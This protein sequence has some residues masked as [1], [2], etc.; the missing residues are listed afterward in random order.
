MT[1]VL[2][3]YE[4]IRASA[5]YMFRADP[6]KAAEFPSIYSVVRAKR[7]PRSEEGPTTP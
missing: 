3:S 1:L 4:H 5:S 2:E 7:R 6:E